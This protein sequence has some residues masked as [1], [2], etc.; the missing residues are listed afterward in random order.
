MTCRDGYPLRFFGLLRPLKK[1]ALDI[2]KI[3]EATR[4]LSH[5]KEW[6]MKKTLRSQEFWRMA[7]S[8]MQQLTLLRY[9]G[10]RSTTTNRVSLAV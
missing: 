1:L 10:L 5:L 8:S 3:G 9:L 4:T 7:S 2:R 6:S